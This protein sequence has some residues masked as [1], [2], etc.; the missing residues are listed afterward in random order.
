MN[1]K[2]TFQVLFFAGIVELPP[3]LV[4]GRIR[5]QV[6]EV[7]T[8]AQFDRNALQFVEDLMFDVEK[9]KALQP[10]DYLALDT[11]SGEFQ[12]GNIFTGAKPERI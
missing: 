8:F 4:H 7:V 11:R 10:G 9:V 12:G 2:L 1:L 5:N 3:S 6:T